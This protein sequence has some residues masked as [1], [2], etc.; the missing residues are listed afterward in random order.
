MARNMTGGVGFGDFWVF[1]ENRQNLDGEGVRDGRS[2]PTY[3][4]KPWP[5]CTGC[6]SRTTA[7]GFRGSRRCVRRMRLQPRVVVLE[8]RWGSTRSART[9]FDRPHC[10]GKSQR[11][12]LSVAKPWPCTSVCACPCEFTSSR[13][14]D[15]GSRRL[16]FARMPAFCQ[17]GLKTG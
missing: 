2:A 4:P 14:H 5:A 11:C 12:G 13:Q 3:V 16:E 17:Q 1:R 9:G 6:R 10:N 15:A 8:C 7:R